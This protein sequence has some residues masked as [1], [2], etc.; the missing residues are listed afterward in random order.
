LT[1]QK[2]T[3]AF[4]KNWRT[5]P[6]SH[7]G[8][9]LKAPP[10][11]LWRKITTCLGLRRKTQFT[12]STLILLSHSSLGII[13]DSK[14]CI[15]KSLW[16]ICWIRRWLS[17]FGTLIQISFLDLLR[18]CW[19]I[20]FVR[21]KEERFYISNIQLSIQLLIDKRE[22]FRSCLR[23]LEFFLTVKKGMFKVQRNKKYFPIRIK[24]FI[25]NRR[26]R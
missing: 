8:S 11:S 20:F 18:Y 23:M 1:Q 5:S 9:Q 25:Q 15:S 26:R 16:S 12:I 24:S 7:K 6:S 17:T 22:R 13:R 3:S 2:L 4:S 21:E 19:G 10:I 14:W